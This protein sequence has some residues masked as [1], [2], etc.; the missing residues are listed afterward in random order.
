MRDRIGVE[1]LFFIC[2]PRALVR[3]PLS[4]NV[5][6]G[7]EDTRAGGWAGIA[8]PLVPLVAQSKSNWCAML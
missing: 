6:L 8:S 7:A 3:L 2:M 4:S 5:K 1:N